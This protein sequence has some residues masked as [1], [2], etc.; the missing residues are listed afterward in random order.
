MKKKYAV[1]VTYKDDGATKKHTFHV[2]ADNREHAEKEVRH[3][4][5]EV[6]YEHVTIKH[7]SVQ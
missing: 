6:G 2:S 1:E 5:K 4:A 7:I 3:Y